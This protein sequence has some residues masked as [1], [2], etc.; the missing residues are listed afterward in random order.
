MT[1]FSRFLCAVAVC[2]GV[3]VVH[4]GE[5]AIP[6]TCGLPIAE[7]EQTESVVSTTIGN[8]DAYTRVGAK[9]SPLPGTS[10]DIQGLTEQGDLGAEL[11]LGTRSQLIGI[12]YTFEKLDPTQGNDSPTYPVWY[13]IERSATANGTATRYDVPIFKYTFNGQFGSGAGTRS[14]AVEVGQ[15][16]LQQYDTNKSFNALVEFNDGRSAQYC[17]QL[18]ELTPANN[19]PE[20]GASVQGMWGAPDGATSFT[21]GSVIVTRAGA[22]RAIMTFFDERADNTGQPVWAFSDLPTGATQF[23]VNVA[24]VGVQAPYNGEAWNCTGLQCRTPSL[25]RNVGSLL[26]IRLGTTTG[27]DESLNIGTFKPTIDNTVHGVT[28]RWAPGNPLPLVPH[29]CMVRMDATPVGLA[30]GS[31]TQQ[32]NCPESTPQQAAY[33]QCTTPQGQSGCPVTLR[34]RITDSFPNARVVAIDVDAPPATAPIAVPSGTDPVSLQTVFSIPAGKSYRFAVLSGDGAAPVIG[35]TQV[36]KASGASAVTATGCTITSGNSTCSANVTWSTSASTSGFVYRVGVMPV[37]APLQVGSGAS[38]TTG[39]QVGAGTYRYELYS[40]TTLIPANR[41]AVSNEISAAGGAG[42]SSVSASPPQCPVIAPSTTCA[43]TVNWSSL[44]VTTGYLFRLALPSTTGQFVQAVGANGSLPQAL[45]VGQYRYELRSSNS[46]TGANLLATS[47]DV[48]V[49]AGALGPP[50]MPTPPVLAAVPPVD[51]ESAAVGFT[52][53]AFRV[54]EAGNATYRIPIEVAPGRAGL[55]PQLAL[56]YSSGNG[57]GVAG[58]GAAVEGSSLITRCAFTAEAGDGM[59]KPIGY[60]ASTYS[61]CMNGQRLIR[62]SGSE[63][64]TGTEYRAEMDGYDRVVVDDVQ[65]VSTNGSGAPITQPTS[66]TVYRKDGLVARYGVGTARRLARMPPVMATINHVI[67]DWWLASLAD[68][69]G[70]TVAYSYSG[71]VDSGSLRL[72]GI[73]YVGGSVDF[74]YLPRPQAAISFGAWGSLLTQKDQLLGVV[75]RSSGGAEFRSYVLNLEPMPSNPALRRLASVVTCQGTTC[76]SP[77]VFAWHDVPAGSQSTSGQGSLPGGG[78]NFQDVRAF[79]YGDING[80]GRADVFWV[81][82][83]K[84]LRVTLSQPGSTG[85]SFAASVYQTSIECEQ[86]APGGPDPCSNEGY[87]RTWTLLDY[88]VDGR[89]DLL[90]YQ[91]SAWRIWLSDGTRLVQSS[92][93][94]PY[95]MSGGPSGTPR[96]M[97]AD[98]DGDGLGD[99]LVNRVGFGSDI[100][101]WLM[102]RSTSGTPY[103]FAGPYPVIRQ[104]PDGTPS[105]DPVCDLGALISSHGDRGD[106]IDFNRDGM[107]DLALRVPVNN[108]S[109]S[110][111]SPE[112]VPDWEAERAADPGS[113]IVDPQSSGGAAV[114]F[115]SKGLNAQGRL[116]F[117][118]LPSL[119]G[120]SSA[121]PEAIRFGDINGDGIVD[122]L[123]RQGGNTSPGLHNWDEVWTYFLGNGRGWHGPTQGYCVRSDVNGGCLP[124]GREGQVSLLDHDG[125]GRMD[126]WSRRYSSSSNGDLGY[127][128]MLW[129]GSGF[130]EPAATFFHGGDSTWMRG[131]ADIDGDGY[132]DNLIMRSTEVGAAWKAKRGTGHHAPRNLLKWIG[133]GLG[134]T[135]FIDYAP[136]TFSTVYQRAYTGHALQSGRAS[137]VHDVLGPRFVVSRVRSTA[138]TENNPSNVAEMRYRYGGFRM[139]GGGRGGL[140][141]ERVVSVDVANSLTMMTE[142]LQSFPLTGLTKRTRN[143]SAA[144]PADVCVN[145]DADACMTYT[146]ATMEP[147]GEPYATMGDTWRWKVDGV[148]ADNPSL[149]SLR[150][151]KPIRVQRSFTAHF[152]RDRNLFL[153][154]GNTTFGSY[155][156]YGNLLDSTSVDFADE[157]LSTVARQVTTINIYDNYP[158][159]WILGRLRE[160][161]VTTTRGALN[162]VRR[163]SFGYNATTGLLEVERLQ[164]GGSSAEA[165]TKVHS[166]DPFGNEVRTAVCA[167]VDENVCRATTASTIMFRS[168]DPLRVQRVSGRSMEPNSLFP[169]AEWSVFQPQGS[170]VQVETSRVVARDAH[171]NPARITDS[172]GVVQLAGYDG[173][174]RRYFGSSATGS[175]SQVER[176][177]CTA[178]TGVAGG[179]RVSCPGGAAY[180][181]KTFSAGG[182]AEWIYFDALDREMLRISRGFSEAQFGAVRKTYDA[183]G[184]IVSVTEP[185]ATF[186]PD[187][188]SVG[189]A[190]GAVYRTTSTYDE[191]GRVVLTTHANSVVGA[192]SETRVVP[193]GRDIESYLPQNLNGV[194]QRTV[195]TVN[196]LGEVVQIRDHLNSLL[197]FTYDAVGNAV[198]VTRSTHD[199]KT[200]TTSASYDTLGRRLT[201]NDPD[202][203][204][205][206]FSYNALGEVVQ[207]SAIGSCEKVL[208]DAAGRAYSRRNYPIQNCS[209]TSDASTDWTY[210]SAAYG[211]G[212]PHVITHTDAG[213]SYSRVHDYDAFGRAS[214][215]TM[216]IGGNDYSTSATYDQFGRPFQGFFEGTN[217][218]RSGELHQYNAAGYA[219]TVRN[220]FPDTTGQVYHEVLSTDAAGRT[221]RERRF[222]NDNLVTE[223]Q[224]QPSTGRT[225]SIRTGGGSLQD[226]S[227]DYDPLGNMRWREDRS[228]GGYLREEFAYDN[229]QRLTSSYSRPASGAPFYS[230]AANYDGLGNSTGFALGTKPDSCNAADEVEPGPSAASGI[231]TNAFCYDAR[232]NQV[233][234]LDPANAAGLEKRKLRYSSYDRAYEVRSNNPFSAHV[235]QF[236][237]GPDR[238][239]VLRN[240]YASATPTGTPQRTYYAGGAEI[241]LKPGSMNR[242]IRRNVSGLLITNVVTATGTAVSQNIDVLL[243]DV[244]GSTH[245]IA[246][247]T[248]LIRPASGQQS[249]AAFGTRT[250]RAT[251]LALDGNGRFNFDDSRTRQGFT[252]HQQADANGLIHMG[253]RMYDPVLARFIQA[254]S[255]VPDTNDLQSLNRYAYV[256]NNPLAYTDPTGH[257]GAQQQGYLRTAVAIVISVYTAGAVA[258]AM[259]TAGAAGGTGSFLGAT[260]TASNAGAYVMVG[261]FAAGAVQTGTLRGATMGAFSAAISFGIGNAFAGADLTLGQSAQRALAHAAAG[262]F[263]EAING[264]KFGHGFISAGVSTTFEPLINTGSDVADATLHTIVGGTAS[265]L[266]G[267]KFANGAMTALFSYAFNQLTHPRT[268]K[269][270]AKF[271]EGEFAE[272][273]TQGVGLN[274]FDPQV[275]RDNYEV[276]TKFPRI[277]GVVMIGAHGDL[278]GSNI[279]L[280]TR[281]GVAV[282]YPASDVA[283]DLVAQGLEVGDHIVVAGCNTASNGFTRALRREL[284]ARGYFNPITGTNA[285]TSF[286][287]R[288]ETQGSRTTTT[289]YFPNMDVDPKGRST[290]PRVTWSTIGGR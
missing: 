282:R 241:I 180:R 209:G 264:G 202:K 163:T 288:I 238:E 144:A 277:P 155:D 233:R 266:S 262:G 53:G 124:V 289:M 75:T 107:A 68:R 181:S 252:G 257:W 42:T 244:L 46:A 210:D 284:V 231:G 63:G 183:Q 270:L 134:A 146:G 34:W 67:E 57:D 200:V 128:A 164:P 158:G 156:D 184:R 212:N 268:P 237:Y 185:Y 121:N 65:T 69:N 20:P 161:T 216:T 98:F 138:P 151:Q 7:V 13:M 21:T 73:N 187:G 56:T 152:K 249:F 207:K 136:T 135:T 279:L 110:S 195:Q 280:D 222:G 88:N 91:N 281:S 36:I 149:S 169:L 70:N 94:L 230:M 11:P 12:F 81:D 175:W 205:W 113:A 28:L 285:S 194:N 23:P 30:P 106:A 50:A 191:F 141:F 150:T 60:D 190:I 79:K 208:Y 174:G 32:N 229:L 173:F 236:V 126:V 85:L 196:G 122:A 93:V 223:R 72:D 225:L 258:P 177:W 78:A 143:W 123:V 199:G 167:A 170:P 186:S 188:A 139:Q 5:P 39:D 247:T 41:L 6:D 38:G 274:T 260:V 240:D 261:G 25:T 172:N 131:F 84:S 132:Y 179:V 217:I 2:A 49:F 100:R 47:N 215:T 74:H 95:G 219:A 14:E 254:D 43:V 204:L 45:A 44:Q 243:T 66:F 192:I 116:V 211:A 22:L 87:E 255:M 153:S 115:A 278:T 213:T 157:N 58:W 201:L 271:L 256:S 109:T 125:D 286:A 16:H 137:P 64:Q 76:L 130:S 269:N 117:V 108:C 239:M 228:G 127:E 133:H 120:L 1:F 159:T 276:A 104:N 218:P 226:L 203:G 3:S 27:I 105:V 154:A 129:N 10:F 148:A 92:V 263:T 178:F 18:A 102:R 80:D 250:D 24:S 272:D 145:P 26:P 176:R 290:S 259:G 283:R 90:V 114:F 221:L 112:S 31:G 119:L 273:G 165:L 17:L 118:T 40:S 111:D 15:L 160:T 140:G 54:D 166:Y 4:A 103:E 287:R 246:D 275:P 61:F 253:A 227:Y 62:V 189:Q 182:A 235:A 86:N 171:G 267:G 97:L 96:V 224:Y 251:G 265:E 59:T 99:I 55:A 232:G 82:K 83:T 162:T 101:A 214:K 19:E 71:D 220:A 9:R 29:N 142:Y 37:A 242:E 248:G 198:T 168:P 35:R 206:T 147:P 33:S 197:S 8:Y 245:R 193:L 52:G 89:E 234:T 51:P 48:N 77:T